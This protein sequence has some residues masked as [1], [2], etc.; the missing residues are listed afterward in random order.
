MTCAT[1]LSRWLYEHDESPKRKHA[2]GEGSAGFASV[3]GVLVGKCPAH[4]GISEAQELLDTAL[5]FSSPRWPHDYPQRLYAVHDG[6]V[7]RATRTRP[8][9]S[10][11]GFPEHPSRFPEGRTGG[12]LKERLLQRATELGC[13]QEVRQWM[14]W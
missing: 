13:E 5:P 12:L 8:G 2:W 11:H 10:Y 6:V 3:R 4:M 1:S 9:V 7:Y 14:D